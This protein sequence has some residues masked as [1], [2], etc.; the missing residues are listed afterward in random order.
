M[1]LLR[2]VT[3]FLK[4]WVFVKTKIFHFIPLILIAHCVYTEFMY[5][6][7]NI[8]N[9][10]SKLL[11]EKPRKREVIKNRKYY[12]FAFDNNLN[13]I[14]NTKINEYINKLLL[15]GSSIPESGEISRNSWSD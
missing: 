3:L 5:F 10:E 13:E 15:K 12:V 11:C 9:F 4:I 14:I 2:S 7:L 1:K 8:V 6:S